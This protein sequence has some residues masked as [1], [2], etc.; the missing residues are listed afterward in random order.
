MI[1]ERCW[2]CNGTGKIEV[3]TLLSW[4]ATFPRRTERCHDCNGTGE[5]AISAM[6]ARTW[7]R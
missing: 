2:T 6:P 7:K 4:L 3:S 5:K 1:T